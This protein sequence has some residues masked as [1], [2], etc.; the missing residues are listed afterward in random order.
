MGGVGL[1]PLSPPLGGL[2]VMVVPLL[3][4]LGA[5][6]LELLL[7]LGLKAGP[8]RVQVVF[9]LGAARL[10][11]LAS[12]L[13]GGPGLGDTSL[14]LRTGLIA[15]GGRVVLGLLRPLRQLGQGHQDL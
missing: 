9:C 6:L 7:R 10:H 13:G 5:C 15:S 12:P 1:G 3:V 4:E 2:C 8:G 11:L 14:D